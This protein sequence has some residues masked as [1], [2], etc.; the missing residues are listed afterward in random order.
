MTSDSDLRFHFFVYR[1][2]FMK[3]PKKK[4]TDYVDQQ[5]SLDLLKFITCGSVDDGKS[6]F[7]LVG[8]V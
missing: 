4:I 8:L 7:G 6:T 5:S 2:A 3:R 1:K